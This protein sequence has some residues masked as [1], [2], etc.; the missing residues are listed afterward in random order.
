MANPKGGSIHNF[1][2]ALDLSILDEYGKELD[3]GTPFD[4]FTPL[5]EPRLE[6]KFLKEGKLTELQIKNRRLLRNVMEQSGFITL[7][8]EWW[9]FDALPAAEVRLHYQIVE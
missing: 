2:F 3:M 6:Q 9:H 5:A 4:D 8:V 1:G 7:P